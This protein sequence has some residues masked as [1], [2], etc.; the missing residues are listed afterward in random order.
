MMTQNADKKREQTS[1]S[2]YLVFDE[3]YDCYLC[4]N[5]QI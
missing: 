2:L 1:Q 5:N 4:P 3:Y